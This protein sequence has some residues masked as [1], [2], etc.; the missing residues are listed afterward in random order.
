M[1]ILVTICFAAIFVFLMNLAAGAGSKKQLGN[2]ILCSCICMVFGFLC[3]QSPMLFVTCGLVGF[4]ALGCMRASEPRRAFRIASIGSAGLAFGIVVVA[5]VL[6]EMREGERLQRELPLESMADRLAY[7]YK[8]P[9]VAHSS[10]DPASRYAQGLAVLETEYDRKNND[11]GV[12]FRRESLQ[13]VHEGVV[14]EFIDSPGLGVGRSI[15]PSRGYVERHP[16]DAPL[17]LAS[18][19]QQEAP[20]P[21]ASPIPSA[22][23]ALAEL[24]LPNSNLQKFHKENLF[25]FL[26]PERF[27]YVQD[28]DHVAGFVS[29]GFGSNRTPEVES[30]KHASW[31]IHDLAL[32]S[33]LKHDPPAAYVS[34]NLPCMEEL[35]EA[36]TR[37]LDTFEQQ[38]LI[39]LNAG[40]DLQMHAQPNRIRMLGS[41]RAAKQC[42]KCHS[43]ERGTLL[44]AFSYDLR[45]AAKP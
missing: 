4:S 34:E 40:D 5:F 27:G 30:E 14:Q 36:P 6:P 37:P 41:L 8:T 2:V 10:I 1:S 23:D 17:P 25:D 19:R 18:L 26:N 33:L 39:A 20:T 32:L 21:A 28:R 43:V 24:T 29:H 45:R 35:R 3:L 12:Q 13:K 44:G 7:E 9:I 16:I 15:R 22:S 38:A 11:F 31:F 42:L